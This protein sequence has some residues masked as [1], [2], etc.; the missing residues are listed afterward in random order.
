MFEGLALFRPAHFL[1]RQAIDERHRSLH[2]PPAGVRGV[3]QPLLVGQRGLVLV[4]HLLQGSLLV[5]QRGLGPG[6]VAHRYSETR[7]LEGEVGLTE[8][9]GKEGPRMQLAN[10]N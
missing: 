3:H 7:F 6:Q 4:A 9:G 1:P 5:V 10:K 8:E 2:L